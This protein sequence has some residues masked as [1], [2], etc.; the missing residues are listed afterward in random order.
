MM[1]LSNLQRYLWLEKARVVVFT[2]YKEERVLFMGSMCIQ[3]NKCT[4]SNVL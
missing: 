2:F 4:I 3:L 1:L